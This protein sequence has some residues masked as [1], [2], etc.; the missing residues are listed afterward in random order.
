MAGPGERFGS[1]KESWVPTD[2]GG[3][4]YLL[5]PKKTGGDNEAVFFTWVQ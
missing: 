4:L 1:G 2:V 5:K 3:F